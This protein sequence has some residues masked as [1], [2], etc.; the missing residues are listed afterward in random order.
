MPAAALPRV[1]SGSVLS[2]IRGYV[3]LKAAIAG[4]KP[5][6]EPQTA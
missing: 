4:S 1:L 3:V 5:A 2:G 6:T